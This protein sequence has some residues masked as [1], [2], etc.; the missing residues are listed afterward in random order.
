MKNTKSETTRQAIL[1]YLQ[2]GYS[3]TALDAFKKFRTLSL[4]QHIEVLRKRGARI[5]TKMERNK[6]TKVN[7]AVYKMFMFASGKKI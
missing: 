3:L 7:Y 4:A 6:K 5:E 1:N 2:S